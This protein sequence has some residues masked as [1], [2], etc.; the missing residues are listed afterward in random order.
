MGA[1]RSRWCQQSLQGKHAGGDDRLEC[2]HCWNSRD[3]PSFLADADCAPWRNCRRCRNRM[4]Q[5][6]WQ[7]CRFFW[8]IH[9]GM[10][11]RLDETERLW[12]LRGSWSARVWRDACALF[13]AWKRDPKLT[14]AVQAS[15]HDKDLCES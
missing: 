4:D 10:D 1:E 9:C 15:L 14:L 5:F 13:R 2:C 7:P 11:Y 12:P 3:F 8:P 6:A